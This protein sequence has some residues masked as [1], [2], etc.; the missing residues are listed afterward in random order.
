[1][2]NKRLILLLVLMSFQNAF[3]D[4]TPPPPPPTPP[5]GLPIDTGVIALLLT[6]LLLGY[7]LIRKINSKKESYR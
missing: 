2:M 4:S 7:Y 6:G 1:M 3:S 5:P